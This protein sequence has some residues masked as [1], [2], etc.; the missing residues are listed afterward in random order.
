VG[1]II[2]YSGESESMLRRNTGCV[3]NADI[4][5]GL[6]FNPEEGGEMFLRNAG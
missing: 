2:I 4:M 3:L 1:Y 6:L 5:L